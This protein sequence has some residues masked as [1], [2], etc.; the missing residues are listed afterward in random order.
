MDV[1]EEFCKNKRKGGSQSWPWLLS[2][3]ALRAR[4]SWSLEWV[5]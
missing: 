3:E 5:V 2:L 4:V 1:A